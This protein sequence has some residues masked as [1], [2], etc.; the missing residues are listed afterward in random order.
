MGKAEDNLKVTL[1]EKTDMLHFLV[2]VSGTLLPVSIL[3]GLLFG[4][5]ARKKLPE[6]RTPAGCGFLFGA[7]GAFLLAVLELTT[8]LVVRE[9]YNLVLLSLIAATEIPLFFLL[10][11]TRS[12]KPGEA[13]SPLLRAAFFLIPLLWGAFY[14]P[15]VFLYPSHFAVGVVQVVSS[16]FVFIVAGYILGILLCLSAGY[17]LFRVCALIPETILFPLFSC[18]LGAFLLSQIINIGQ[19]LLGRGLVP[20]SDSALD[21][22]IFLLNNADLLLYCIIAAAALAILTLL[23]LSGKM[24]IEGD[25]PA[26]RRKARSLLRGRMRW[27]GAAFCSL[28][29]GLLVVTAGAALSARKEELSPPTEMTAVNGE[30]PHPT[31]LVGD[32]KL[33]RFVFKTQKGINVRYIIIKKSPSAYGVGL[34]ACEVCGPSGYYE[35]KGQV[36]CM[37]C[38]VVMNKS[39]IG[40]A[41]GCNPVPLRFS[42]RE[43]RLIIGTKELEAAAPRFR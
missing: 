42:L 1:L 36:V 20:R 22:I 35:R 3:A 30:I 21:A 43:G 40:F 29:A 11:R 18:A 8:A 28:L 14:L 37:L 7:A 34:D 39:T 38:D 19:T 23:R 33:H 6:I 5:A 31:S 17:S 25:N 9:Y 15:D 32:G 2:Q 10:L 13:A 12:S 41:G 16:E 4:H 24:P 27:S 26:L